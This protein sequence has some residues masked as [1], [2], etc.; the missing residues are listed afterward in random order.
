MRS[1]E[2]ET[3][4]MRSNRF[5][6]FERI[7]WLLGREIGERW[8]NSE[9]GIPSKHLMSQVRCLVDFLTA[10]ALLVKSGAQGHRKAVASLPYG[11]RRNKM[12]VHVANK[13]REA[14]LCMRRRK[15]ARSL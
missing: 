14:Y 1:L 15:A 5:P 4:G 9:Y 6:Q 3:P 2:L 12:Y 8:M 13:L 7:A 11:Y 10:Q